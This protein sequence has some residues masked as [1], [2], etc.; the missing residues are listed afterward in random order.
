M[1][2]PNVN[3]TTGEPG[4]GFTEEQVMRFLYLEKV[5]L[6]IQLAYQPR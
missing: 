6:Y 5:L 2:P 1:L 4:L 3:D